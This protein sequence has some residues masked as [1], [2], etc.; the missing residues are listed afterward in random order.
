M[1]LQMASKSGSGMQVS[2]EIFGRDF[3]EGLVHQAVVAY[4]AGG[5]SG[6]RAQKNRSDCRGGGAKPWAQKGGGRAR[7][8]TSRSPIWRSGGVTFAARP[9]DHSQKLNKKMYKTAMRS[10]LS[11]LVRQER[12]IVVKEFSVTSPKTREMF[13]KL[14]E[15]GLVSDPKKAGSRDRLLIVSEDADVNLFL[16]AR[17][18]PYV[19]VEDVAGLN[20]VNLIGSEKV[21][22]TEASVKALEEKL[23]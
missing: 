12:L 21:V 22:M 9:Q 3:N 1:E 13:T 8:G 10:I 7:A 2:D 6:T 20:P 11:E 23:A 18:L 19:N 16:G 14:N 15:L 17:N 4:L 5:R